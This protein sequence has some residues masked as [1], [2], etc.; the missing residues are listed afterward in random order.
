MQ[1]PVLSTL[2]ASA[3]FLAAPFAAR[4][5]TVGFT[6]TGGSLLGSN[7]A[8]FGYT[9]TLATPV[10]VTQLG[11]WDYQSD[12]LLAAIPVTIWNDSGTPLATATVPAGTS[13]GEINQY[14]YVTLATPVTLAA[15]T[16]TLGG[17]TT[18]NGDEIQY[19]LATING[20]AGV[21]Y[22]ASRAAGGNTYPTADPLVLTNSYF[23]PN[24]QFNAVPEP[25]TWAA[26][27]L[28]LASLGFVTL[29]RRRASV[30]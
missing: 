10:R 30:A 21:T 29:R 5:D 25:S 20:A 16:Y 18:N 14:L 2:L 7:G 27:G 13:A 3:A 28:G 17:Y 24:F 15:G 8:T 1:R 4:A 23:G 6:T 19:S 12:G 26:A 11:F 9:F 22:G